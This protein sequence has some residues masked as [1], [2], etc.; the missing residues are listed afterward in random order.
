MKGDAWSLPSRPNDSLKLT[1]PEGDLTKI[2]DEKS[3]EIRERV[4]N[5]KTSF[6]GPLHWCGRCHT[7]RTTNDGLTHNM[8]RPRTT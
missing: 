3:D 7:C 4:R 8:T 5:I 1:L 2:I 6:D